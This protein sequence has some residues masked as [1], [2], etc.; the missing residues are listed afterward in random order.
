MFPL[1]V[2][3][4]AGSKKVPYGIRGARGL[5]T[6][7]FSGTVPAGWTL[8]RTSAGQY[9][10]VHDGSANAKV[11]VMPDAQNAG[12]EYMPAVNRLSPSPI[13]ISTRR[14][15]DGGVLDGSFW[16]YVIDMGPDNNGSVISA[17]VAS[18]GVFVG[19]TPAGWSILK[20]AQGQYTLTVDWN[21]DARYV[22][23]PANWCFFVPV[24]GGGVCGTPS[25]GTAS[26]TYL[27]ETI[28]L[29]DGN[30]F[31]QQFFIV[32]VK[33]GERGPDNRLQVASVL[34][35]GTF[36]PP[37]PTGWTIARPSTGVYTLGT[38]YGESI[39][40]RQ[41]SWGAWAS[42]NRLQANQAVV[43]ITYTGNNVTFNTQRPID[44]GIE[45]KS[46]WPVIF[47]VNENV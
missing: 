21:T 3:A 8:T 16:V 31:D 35:G 10:F 45:N 32:A 34:A 47:K 23:N 40:P 30:K 33:S 17:Q 14:V 20:T 4:A 37:T 46:F 2:A 6:G 22:A 39:D 19:G 9:T 26:V 28:R 24:T 5:G 41:G 12:T 11:I 25:I 15:G 13:L 38:G 44:F 29:A 27:I 43:A 7:G 18:T 1:N 36:G 42:C